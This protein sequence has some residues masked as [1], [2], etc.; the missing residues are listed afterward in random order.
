MAAHNM[1][2]KALKTIYDGESVFNAG[3]TFP[4]R[5]IWCM[6]GIWRVEMPSGEQ[7]ELSD[8]RILS[9]EIAP[10]MD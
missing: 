1:T 3:D 6:G 10:V 9:P 7:R 8:E 2:F 4:V 5:V